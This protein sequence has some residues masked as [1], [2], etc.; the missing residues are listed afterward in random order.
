MY[1]EPK[2]V[3]NYKSL[4]AQTTE[5]RKHILFALEFVKRS[6]QSDFAQIKNTNLS[7]LRFAESQKLLKPEE[8]DVVS[9]VERRR[10]AVDVMCHRN[11][12]S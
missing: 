1:G 6:Q 7:S 2:G 8:V 12:P 10:G 5:D 11:A 3:F 4:Q 9:G